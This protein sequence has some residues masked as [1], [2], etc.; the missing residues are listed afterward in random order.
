M[1]DHF[2][3]AYI[4]VKEIMG[5]KREDNGRIEF[6]ADESSE[7]A[8]FQRA[9]K[10]GQKF[11]RE[12]LLFV[13]LATGL[14]VV[15]LFSAA[16]LV[17]ELQEQRNLAYILELSRRKMSDFFDYVTGRGA[18]NGIQFTTW[19]CLIAMVA[20]ATLSASGAVYQGVFRNILA[21]P[22]TLGVQS[23]GTVGNL[24][25][26]LIFVSGETVIYQMDLE[27]YQENTSFWMHNI[28]Q[29]MVLAGCF[30]AVGLVL[31]IATAAGR[32]KIQ[33]SS[34]ILAGMVFSSII[35]TAT[36]LVQYV[37]I[38]KN[39]SDVRIQ[40]IRDLSM[41]SFNRVFQIDNVLL[42]LG[43]LI[44]CFAVL[45]LMSGRMDIFTLGEDAARTMGL[46]VRK[47][48]NLIVAVN[49]VMTAVI[50]AFCGQIGFIGFIVPLAARRLAGPSYR[51][52]L[53][54]SMLLGAMLM[55]VVYD[56]AVILH[57]TQYMNVLTSALGSI[58]MM[59][60]FFRSRK[61]A[62]YAD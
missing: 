12:N 17:T 20:G 27:T 5:K 24:T 19:R 58:V 40:M 1:A 57:F 55:L 21:T 62:A 56:I 53:P 32:G 46:P 49:T 30:L 33:S 28:Q 39:P 48:R 41:G 51:R 18:K 8:E 35:S 26:A 16:M 15:F 9:R 45:F 4:L 7:A 34:L 42:M 22:S 61:A 50:I 47:F 10:R 2:V 37:L 25:Y 23:G 44:P 38:E 3:A 29:L 14:A 60:S 31:G 43:I 13:V 59:A 54:A 36:G 52:L 11:H 6:L